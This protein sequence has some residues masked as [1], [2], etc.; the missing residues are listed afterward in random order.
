[1]LRMAGGVPV[2]DLLRLACDTAEHRAVEA[3]EPATAADRLVLSDEL[4]AG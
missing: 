1:M 2:F 4:P 3:C